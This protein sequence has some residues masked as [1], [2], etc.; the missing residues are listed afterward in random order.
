[1]SEY[2]PVTLSFKV[3]SKIRE[4]IKKPKNWFGNCF[5]ILLFDSRAH[6]SRLFSSGVLLLRNA[7]MKLRISSDAIKRIACLNFA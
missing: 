2:P 3:L 7:F 4:N 1:M 6:L 5:I